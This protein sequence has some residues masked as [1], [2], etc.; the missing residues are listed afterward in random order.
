M[1]ELPGSS[2]PL[3]IFDVAEEHLAVDERL[4]R[5]FR[6]WQSKR[7]GRRLPARGDL[8]PEE[9]KPWFGNLIV[10]D[11][12]DAGR[13]FRYRLFGTNIVRQAGFDMTGKLLSE[14]PIKDAL[15]HFFATHRE[16]VRRA[17]PAFGEHN[18]RVVHVRRRRR[19]I[20]PFGEDGKTVDRTLTANY[21][22]EV[23]R[24]PDS[25]F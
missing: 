1:S 21:A 3:A 20:L 5:L 18:P 6:L 15:P 22:I 12:I 8:R 9:L 23:V 19:L 4:L 24:E 17:T 7:R 25:Y 16:V 2:E 10:L 14:Y 13:D 11:V